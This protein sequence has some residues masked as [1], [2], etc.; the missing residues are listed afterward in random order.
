[1]SNSKL[2]A[3]QK[4]DRKAYKRNLLPQGVQLF[5]FPD[6]GVTVAMRATGERMGEFSASIASPDEKKFRRKV[7]EF[8]ALRRFWDG[9]VCPVRLPSGRDSMEVTAELIAGHLA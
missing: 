3:E 7:G 5:S 8:H 9:Q 6:V 1:M 2:T 4:A